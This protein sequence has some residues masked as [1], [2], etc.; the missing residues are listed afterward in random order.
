MSTI[1]TFGP[2][3]QARFSLN[4]G[5]GIFAFIFLTFSYFLV[6]SVVIVAVKI[7][8][9]MRKLYMVLKYNG[10]PD[11]NRGNLI[12]HTYTLNCTLNY[13]HAYKVAYYCLHNVFNTSGGMKSFHVL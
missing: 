10:M 6:Q 11:G 12:I 7:H 13:T 8:I 2:H 3:L 4:L 9:C 5:F 1:L